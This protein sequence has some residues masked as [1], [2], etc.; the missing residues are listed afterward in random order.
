MA[1]L[2]L[3]FS[4][5][6][7]GTGST[8]TS[9]G[10]LLMYGLIYTT[11][12]FAV[13]DKNGIDTLYATLPI[14]KSDV[15]LG[16]YLFAVAWNFFIALIAIAVS[17]VLVTVTSMQMSNIEIVASVFAMF[18]VFTF[19]GAIQLPIYFKFGYAKA[20]FLA[21]LPL[22]GFP[23]AVAVVTALPGEEKAIA[24]FTEMFLW[25]EANVYLAIAVAIVFW[26]L[27]MV[28]SCGISYLCYRNREF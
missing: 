19:I 28:V 2:A 4:F 6:G 12:P 15:V 23:A 24:W 16:R 5:I 11:Y 18:F 20:K 14:K 7:F 13:G 10:L 17:L 25:V 22:A 26:A 21:Y 3:V 8:A 9:I 27:I 1:L